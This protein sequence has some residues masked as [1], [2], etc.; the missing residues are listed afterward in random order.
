MKSAKFTVYQLKN[1][2]DNF[3]EFC[4]AI[5]NEYNSIQQ[6]QQKEE[7]GINIYMLRNINSEKSFEHI[8]NL[9]VYLAIHR[10][11]PQ[12][13]D[14]LDELLDDDIKYIENTSHSFLFFIKCRN[15]YF[16]ITGGKGHLVISEYKNYSF[17]LEIL[18]KIMLPKDNIIKSIGDRSFQGNRFSGQ[19]HFNKFVNL[20][21]ENN[22]S[23][24]FKQI[25]TFLTKE[26]IYTEFG[27]SIKEKKDGFN[28][29]AKD[30]IK[31]GKSLNLKE[32]ENL[33]KNLDRL[34]NDVDSEYN[35]NKFHE[36]DHRDSLFKDLNLQLEHLIFDLIDLSIEEVK[37]SNIKLINSN[38]LYLDCD[39]YVLKKRTTTGQ[40]LDRFETDVDINDIIA[41]FKK[42]YF[43]KIFKSG[44][45]IIE[46][47]LKVVSLEGYI[48]NDRVI[49]ERL[50][51][52]LDVSL[53]YD[54]T[55]YVLMNGKWF[56]LD[57]NFIKEVDKTFIDKVV[58]IYES[59]SKT[60]TMKDWKDG[61]DEGD[62]NFSYNINDDYYVLD[63]ML[64][65]NVEV[66]D[67]LK[68]E[69]EETFLIHVKD[70]LAGSTRI[71]CEQILI[72]MESIQAAK[73]YSDKDFLSEYYH[74]IESK[75]KSNIS[76]SLRNSAIK[77]LNK[78]KTEEEFINFILSQST[79]LT[80]VFA[81]KSKNH[82]IYKPKTITSTPAKISILNLISQVKQYD[83]DLKIVEIGSA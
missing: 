30:S 50:L 41:I 80:F 33:I 55:H 60:I 22:M 29:L 3:E 2:N 38:Y 75:N 31:L 56:Y 45:S 47:F 62:Y 46:D 9:R 25:N 34:I 51:D 68:I 11:P 79:K 12:W 54:N 66:C 36:V 78:F 48:D 13:K 10:T 1:N 61:D 37:E 6:E 53:I 15:N 44:K 83:F 4:D 7:S 39:Y 20:I 19:Q 81:F 69:D 42:F 21:S 58:P 57:S 5:V 77:F 63:K 35:I 67:L 8:D 28:F 43:E 23:N 73:L 64:V 76:H 72:A 26:K 65:R 74:S 27:V 32:L 16:A 70:G 17:G 82:D 52:L 49:N 71:L 14:T 24:Y 59:S 18:S 40:E